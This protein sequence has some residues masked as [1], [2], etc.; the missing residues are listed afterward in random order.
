[1]A[2]FRRPLSQS[3]DLLP[4]GRSHN[5][6]CWQDGHGHAHA[7]ARGHP[8][9]SRCPSTPENAQRNGPAECFQPE[10]LLCLLS[11]KK[12]VNIFFVF[13]WEFCIEKMAGFFGG[14]FLVSVSHETKHEKILENFGENS[15]QNS[16][17][18]SGR[19]FE[20]LG[21]FSFCNFPDLTNSGLIFWM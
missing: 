4:S 21:R 19:K 7:R 11:R 10:F 2:P 5:V 13:A 12:L 15:E 20:K 16:G 17:Q 18:N 9:T 8:L 6:G 1:M 14:F 3:A